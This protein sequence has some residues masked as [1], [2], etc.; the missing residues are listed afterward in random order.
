MIIDPNP[1]GY[2]LPEGIGNSNYLF[3]ANFVYFMKYAPSVQ[4]TEK[5][6]FIDVF[7]MDRNTSAV[8]VEN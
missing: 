3:V 1:P 4:C 5:L 7:L 6:L 8:M 2:K